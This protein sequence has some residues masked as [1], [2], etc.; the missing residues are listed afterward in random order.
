[1]EN[2]GNGLFSP[3]GE[4]VGGVAIGTTKVASGQSHEDA[5]QAGESAFALQA[6]VDFVD[7][8]CF[9]HRRSL[10]GFAAL[11][12]SIGQRGWPSKMV[13]RFSFQCPQGGV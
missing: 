13:E 10:N 6:Q 1:M 9:G 3:F 7:D 11:V 5:G 4:R 12:K 2:V 8:Q